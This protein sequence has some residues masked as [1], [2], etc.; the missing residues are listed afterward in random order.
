MEKVNRIFI[1][2]ALN[3][4]PKMFVCV[5]QVKLW[6]AKSPFKK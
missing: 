4:F 1:L 2:L 3:C 5:N 6:G